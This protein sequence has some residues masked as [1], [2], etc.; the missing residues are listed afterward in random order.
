MQMD[1]LSTFIEQGAAGLKI[2]TE[3]TF[4]QTH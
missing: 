2:N 4:Q 3:N 1:F